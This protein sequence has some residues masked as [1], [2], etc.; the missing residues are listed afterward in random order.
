MQIFKNACLF[1]KL[2]LNILKKWA[3]SEVINN[4]YK[5]IIDREIKKITGK[6][7]KNKGQKQ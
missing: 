6:K 5:I 2:M 4:V 1:K 3:D 7:M